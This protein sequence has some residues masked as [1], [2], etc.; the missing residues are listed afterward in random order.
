M[1]IVVC[2]KQVPDTTEVKI[3][4]KTGRLIREGVPSII[5]PEDKNALEEALRIKE[6]INSQVTV[7]TMGPPQAEDALR[8]ALAMG[9]DEGILLC[10]FKF[11]GSDTWA[12]ANALKAGIKQIGKYDL[13]LC[14]RQAIDGDTAQVGPQLAEALQIP[15]I[16]Y[17]QKIEIDK[18]N[19]KKVKVEREMEDGYEIIE[20]SLPVLV[21]CTHSINHP[22]YPSL[23]G[24]E[25]SFKAEIK[26]WTAADINAVDS[27]I[28]INSSPTKVK[29]TFSPQA[30]GQGV[31]LNGSIKEMAHEL[32]EKLK[33][34]E[35]IQKF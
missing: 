26:K 3:D 6:K 10:D 16:T 21:T 22:R 15:Q 28:G 12:T 2:I 4:Q 30:K 1:N 14:G 27:E 9:A 32:I 23:N 17:A 24:I 20:S 5:N 8:E 13:I 35:I 34:K 31:I 29:K 7:V 11:A 25:N 18:I 19:N 33:E